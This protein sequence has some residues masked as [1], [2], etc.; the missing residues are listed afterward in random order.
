MRTRRLS[1]P[2]LRNRPHLRKHSHSR[3]RPL[4]LTKTSE[5]LR[6]CPVSGST[7]PRFS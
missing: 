1:R 3:D 6:R 4:A 5:I 7:S 2:H